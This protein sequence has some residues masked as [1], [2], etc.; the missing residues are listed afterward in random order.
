MANVL[1]EELKETGRTIFQKTLEA[2]DRLGTTD[3]EVHEADG[4]LEAH[5][6]ETF[7]EV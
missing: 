3:L 5:L 2:V 7:I 4:W 6:A 1:N